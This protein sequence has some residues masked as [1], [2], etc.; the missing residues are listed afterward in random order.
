LIIFILFKDIRYIY[1]HSIQL[2][3]CAVSYFNSSISCPT[4]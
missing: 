4:Y 2:Y 1:I 3:N